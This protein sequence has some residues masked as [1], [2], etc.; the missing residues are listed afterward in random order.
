[1]SFNRHIYKYLL[2]WKNKT[3]RKPLILRG[4][5]Q[6]G[7]TTLAKSFA[8][9]YTYS[10]FLN[11][12]KQSDRDYFLEF[13]EMTQLCDVLLLLNN[14]P[15]DKKHETLLFI[16][17]IQESPKAIQ[18]L[19]YFYEEVPEL[20]VIAAGSLLEIALKEVKSFPV[21][22]VEFAYLYPLNFTEFLE[23]LGHQEALK[24]LHQVPV[25]PFAHSILLS[26]FHEYALVGGLPEAVAVY[27]ENRFLADLPPI[28]ESIWRSYID[29]VS[30]YAKN[31]AESK[32][33]K[34]IM[35]VAPK[36]VDQR[37]SFQNFGNSNYRSR[38]ISEAFYSL[39]AAKIIQ[40]VYPTTS[41]ENPIEGDL[42]KSPRLQFLD[43][44]IINHS[45]HIQAE[46]LAMKDLSSAYK[47]AIIPHL[48]TQELISLFETTP[49]Q[50]HFW[51]RE[52]RQ[53]SAEVDLVWSHAPYLIPFEI[54]SGKTGTLRS[55]HQFI[56]A[57][58]H[59]FAV[60]IYGGKLSIEEHKTI[61]G[62][63]FT[64][65]NLPYY[66][67]TKLPEYVKYLVENYNN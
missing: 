18:Q 46:L 21:G 25:A 11:L 53:S 47:G 38:E 24:Q 7:K 10:I 56:D 33:I 40:L 36:Y 59:H 26:L 2:K 4:A 63:P 48:I 35:S 49:Y 23:A 15:T 39:N 28:Y 43:T 6:V 58:I 41:L 44:G 13:D 19:R 5:R 50:P 62:K 8:K 55:L 16:D 34:H 51:V 27:L 57:S 60:R 3:R 65:L 31:T 54:K 17:E 12:E 64:L 29:D 1:M 61:A 30:K 14:V 22:R 20:H 37:I 52:K 45:L 66:L 9:E 32:I 67:G 42:K